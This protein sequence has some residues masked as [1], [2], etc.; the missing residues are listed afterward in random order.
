MTVEYLGRRFNIDLKPLSPS[1]ALLTFSILYIATVLVWH[2]L[3]SQ[4][5]SD[6]RN[7]W[8]AFLVPGVPVV[9]YVVRKLWAILCDVTFT[10]ALLAAALGLSCWALTRFSTD[11]AYANV[12]RS[13]A[14]VI[15][16]AA[17]CVSLFALLIATP[18]TRRHVPRFMLEFGLLVIVA[19]AFSNIQGRTCGTVRL[20][21]GTPESAMTLND[22]VLTVVSQEGAWTRVP[23]P[24]DTLDQPRAIDAG[25]LSMAVASAEKSSQTDAAGLE[26]TASDGAQTKTLLLFYNAGFS[27][28]E[29]GQVRRRVAFGPTRLT[30]PF[31]VSLTYAGSDNLSAEP[32]LYDAC[33]SLRE[34][35]SGRTL[36]AQLCRGSSFTAYGHSV[37]LAGIDKPWMA[38]LRIVREPGRPL[39]MA[40]GAMVALGVLAAAWMAW[41]SPA[42]AG[43]IIYYCRAMAS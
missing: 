20:V 39:L 36:C 15:L 40:G 32:S 17:L 23:L 19:G 30:L 34:K 42:A 12:F 33:L 28:L 14:F 1:K 8:P 43:R 18:R 21:K 35:S 2:S 13:C 16:L 25:D 24:M 31:E 38:T 26:V 37:T 11:A 22:F 3:P 27:L 7:F 9:L 6:L 10:A 5:A 4:A 41:V 29:I